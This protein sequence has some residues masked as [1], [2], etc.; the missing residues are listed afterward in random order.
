V[1]KQPVVILN[2]EKQITN[3]D[4]KI[5]DFSTH[6]F[7]EIPEQDNPAFMTKK[8]WDEIGENGCVLITK[9][10]EQKP[11]YTNCGRFSVYEIRVVENPMEE[12]TVRY[13]GLFWE[14]EHALLF[15]KAFVETF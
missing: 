11:P 10:K 14:I 13:L 3:K 2:I 5:V 7:Q 12:D 1:L 4:M 8:Q 15:S 9:Q 6:T